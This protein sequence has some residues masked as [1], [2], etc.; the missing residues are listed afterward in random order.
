MSAWGGSLPAATQLRKDAVSGAANRDAEGR[1]E[2]DGPAIPEG[3]E[4]REGEDP[5]RAL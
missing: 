1:D 5:R 4:V 2:A 3:I